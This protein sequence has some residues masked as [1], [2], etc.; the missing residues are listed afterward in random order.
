MIAA[1]TPQLILWRHAEAHDPA[2][3]ESD[4]ERRLTPHGR[5]Q[6]QWM[7]KWLGARLPKDVRVLCS[8]ARRAQETAHA[9]TKDVQEIPALQLVSDGANFLSAIGWP[10]EGTIVVVGHQPTLG[11]AASFLIAGKE[12]DWSVKKGAVWWIA[13]HKRDHDA[14]VIRAVIAPDLARGD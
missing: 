11:R 12:S 4:F 3:G 13:R 14:H 9:L 10:V 1:A 2:P 5:E 7:A 6:A 8:P